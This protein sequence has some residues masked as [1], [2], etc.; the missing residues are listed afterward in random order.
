MMRESEFQLRCVLAKVAGSLEALI[1]DTDRTLD[2]V[3]ASILKRRLAEIY[4]VM[5][6]LRTDAA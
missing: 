5:P 2:D 6:H 1:E 3:T 4:D